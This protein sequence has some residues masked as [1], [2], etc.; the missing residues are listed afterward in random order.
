M[1]IVTL[2][3]CDREISRL[4]ERVQ[5]L[6]LGMPELERGRAERL[7]EIAALE[8]RLDELWALK[9]RL[10][11]EVDWGRSR[12]AAVRAPRRDWAALLGRARPEAPG[13]RAGWARWR[14]GR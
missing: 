12:P 5:R 6:R 1:A 14:A 7:L 11:A 9:R 3:D 13:R 8:A 10:R 4:A 2:A